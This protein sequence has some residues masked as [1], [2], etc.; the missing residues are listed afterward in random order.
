MPYCKNKTHNQGSVYHR[1]VPTDSGNSSRVGALAK[2]AN[3]NMLIVIV[4]ISSIALLGL[5]ILLA[6]KKKTN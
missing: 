6:K 1:L 5:T 2:S 3:V 4:S